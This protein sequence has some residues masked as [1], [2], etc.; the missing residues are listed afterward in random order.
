MGSLLAPENQDN[1]K[2]PIQLLV[3]LPDR[4]VD[5]ATRFLNFSLQDFEVCTDE[6]SFPQ[7]AKNP[8]YVFKYY[9]D[10]LA[11]LE[12]N[13]DSEYSLYW[14][15]SA[16][17]NVEMTALFYTEFHSLIGM[18]IV[19]K[20]LCLTMFEELIEQFG[21][22]YGFV[23]DDGLPPFNPTD[24]VSVATDSALPRIVDGVVYRL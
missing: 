22:K 24:F 12:K 2:D 16:S 3:M 7:Y 10:L 5:I 14:R 8:E 23:S 4:T 15:N 21:I 19:S 1:M 18:R 11:L 17:S 6:L 20:E 13:I 9:S